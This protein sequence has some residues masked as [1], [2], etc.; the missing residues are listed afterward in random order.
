[1]RGGG[2]EEFDTKVFERVGAQMTVMT[3][4]HRRPRAIGRQLATLGIAVLAGLLLAACG[5][6]P[7]GSS[8]GSGSG[9]G[10]ATPTPVPSAPATSGGSS[11]YLSVDSASKSATLTLNINGY[12]FDGFSNGQMT[13]NIPEGW[14]VTVQCNNKAT[15][16][17]SCAI[18]Q[19]TSSTSPAFSGASTADP[20]SGLQPNA[21]G[22]FTF[23]ASST[24][25]FLIGC[26]VPGHM[27]A[28]MWDHFDVTSSGSPSVST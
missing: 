28:G 25:Q 21:S 13:V 7:S 18:V 9:S 20:T 26:L 8:G 3:W 17:H 1:M 19:S 23:T 2:P 24:G 14:S 12:N 10:S 22:S 15:I 16:P 5:S 11:Q 6:S 4:F 27:S